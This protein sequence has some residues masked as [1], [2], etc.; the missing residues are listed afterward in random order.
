MTAGAQAYNGYMSRLA[1]KIPELR[2]LAYE[3][4][5]NEQEQYLKRLALARQMTD[6]EEDEYDKNRAAY[7]DYRDGENEKDLNYSAVM[8]K[9]QTGGFSSLSDSDIRAIY[10]S[11]SYYDPETNRIKS[12]V[13][14]GVRSARR[15]DGGRGGLNARFG[16]AH[17]VPLQGH[18]HLRPLGL[19]HR[20]AP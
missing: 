4:Y 3:K 19:G 8:V 20:G 16:G 11:G 9:A 13:G 6:D 12:F 2:K 5:L 17:Q 1:D 18:G 10:E 14:R 15:R 7:L